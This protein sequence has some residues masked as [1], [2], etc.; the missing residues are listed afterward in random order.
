MI[1]YY[2]DL[3]KQLKNIKEKSLSQGQIQKIYSTAF[4]VSFTLRARGK[5]WHLYLGRGGGHEGIW[6][7]DTAPPSALR[8]KDNFLEYLRRHVTSCSFQD[9]SLDSYDRIIRLDYLKFG[10]LQSFLFFWK[11]RKLY[12]LHHYQDRP[13]GEFKLL[14]SWRGKSFAPG[15]E[16]TDLF[17][18]FDEIGRDKQMSHEMSSIQILDMKKLLDDEQIAASL[19]TLNS[20]PGFLQRKKE[21]IESD[22]RKAR[23]WEKLQSIL[24]RGDSLDGIYE[25]KVEDQKIKF[26]GDLNPYERRNLLY[27]KIKKLKRG[28]N[29]LKE[30]LGSVESE[31]SGKQS[32][33]LR[34]SQIP[35]I[36]P[37]W[38]EE[39]KSTLLPPTP[40][41]MD[42]KVFNFDGYS[43]GV[44]LNAQGNDQLRNKWASKE[45]HWL[46]MDGLKS[47]HVIIKLQN[48]IFG[49]EILNYGASI[50]AHFSHF[51]GDWIPIIHTHVKNL[52]GVSGAPGMVIYKKE[53]HLRCPRQD[54]QNIIKD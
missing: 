8:R 50:L 30:R 34:T 36:K 37:I 46:H 44:G 24:D 6:L 41:T 17:H 40:Q 9:L 51:P 29:I 35:M 38:G 53:K 54:L 4:Y 48:K 10:E 22:L 7:H 20:P 12:F 23:Q 15:E 21:N 47:C 32:N 19:T 39:K 49:P 5:T 45:D 25:L 28:E 52:K 26:E 31:L 43:V 42:F 27:Q 3:E 13:E 1:Q 2:L 11:G 18:Y 14:L 33:E 16:L